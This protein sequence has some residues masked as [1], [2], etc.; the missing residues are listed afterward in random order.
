MKF[1]S[2]VIALSLVF[3][4]L[5]FAQDVSIFTTET[6]ELQGVDPGILELVANATAEIEAHFGSLDPNDQ[7][8][9]A[10]K[11]QVDNQLLQYFTL[12]DLAPTADIILN[13]P[14]YRLQVASGISN[15]TSWRTQAI[16]DLNGNYTAW[17]ARIANLT[18]ERQ[19][20]VASGNSDL[21]KLKSA[22]V[23]NW[24]KLSEKA[25]AL[26]IDVAIHTGAVADLELRKYTGLL[27][28]ANNT[29]AIR[30]VTLNVS[31]TVLDKPTLK[32]N[33]TALWV[34][35]AVAQFRLAKLLADLV[36][37]RADIQAAFADLQAKVD[38][39][40]Q[41]V[42]EKLDALRAAWQA[43]STAVATKLAERITEF[44]DNVNSTSVT[45]QGLETLGNISIDLQIV[46]GTVDGDVNAAKEYLR[47]HIQILIAAYIAAHPSN[48][49]VSV[50]AST[51]RQSGSTYS[52]SVIV[53]PSQSGGGTYADDGAAS[54]VTVGF[55]FIAMII[56]ALVQ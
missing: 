56:A 16:V 53:G 29:L 55:A 51:K 50:S 49:T 35:S 33:I 54:S 11:T 13:L 9:L 20:A 45:I 1:L 22:L 23:Y 19:A 7:E 2:A 38:Q 31:W 42:Y 10:I 43:N 6:N 26:T 48:V 40:K 41:N 3:A 4:P 8:L 17:E 34:A 5:I 30:N 12:I 14:T 32:A 44:L 27:I 47:S 21:E 39:F 25:A 15:F 36:I 52:S 46:A 28:F 24:V 37:I 18:A